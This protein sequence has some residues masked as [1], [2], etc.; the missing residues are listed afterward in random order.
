MGFP[1]RPDYEA[2]YDNR[3]RVPEHPAI[4]AQWAKDAAAWR[5]ERPP[6]TL[7][8]GPSERQ[9]VDLFGVGDEPVVLFVHG[10]YW[11]AMD[12]SLFSHMAR[13][14][15]L[16]GVGV[17]VVGY[18]LCP[19]VSLQD[20]VK[21]VR[22]ACRAVAAETG[23]RVVVSG[24]S[25]GGHL[26]ACMLALEP[27]VVRAAYSLSG[28]FELAPLT[29]TR[30]NQALR[31]TRAEAERLSPL[32]WPAPAGATLDAVVGEHESA[33]FH[34]QSR[35]IVERWGAGGVA[36]RYESVSGANHFTVVVGTA[37]PDSAMVRR[38][39]ELRE[40]A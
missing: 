6:R 5:A 12:R 8:Y 21:Q 39:L 9:A 26:A 29:E 17:G 3:A 18:D 22:A 37:D 30:L 16:N 13:G 19:E 33:E 23:G 25:A 35:E 32:S 1:D 7:A 34:R 40:A 27:A 10:G 11:Q 4:F 36:A 20:I 14:L 24:H 31:L 15:N 2:E 38:L 28:L